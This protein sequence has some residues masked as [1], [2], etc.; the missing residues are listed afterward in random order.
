MFEGRWFVEKGVAFM[1]QSNNA[2]AF[3]GS[4]LV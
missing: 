1:K 4:C 3:H 2:D